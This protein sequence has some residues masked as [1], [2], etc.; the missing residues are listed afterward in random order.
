MLADRHVL[1]ERLV[2]H[3]MLLARRNGDI[4]AGTLAH[5]IVFL[6]YNTAGIIVDSY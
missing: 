2:R 6:S 3:H 5:G 1:G 4:C